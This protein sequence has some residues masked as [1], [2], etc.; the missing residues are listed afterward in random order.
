V[1]LQIRHVQD[2]RSCS[3]ALETPNWVSINGNR[4]A[5]LGRLLL[6]LTLRLASLLCGAK[7]YCISGC[8]CFNDASALGYSEETLAVLVMM[9]Q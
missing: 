3:F 1:K 7:L 5:E 4:F 6:G 8:S 9:Q 2:W